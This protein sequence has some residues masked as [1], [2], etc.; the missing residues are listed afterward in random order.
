MEKT[1]VI[2]CGNA[3]SAS[4]GGVKIVLDSKVC[5]HA[6]TPTTISKSLWTSSVEAVIEYCRIVFDLFPDDYQVR[7]YCVILQ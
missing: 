7:I 3:L 4:L 5:K 2:V 1:V 6:G